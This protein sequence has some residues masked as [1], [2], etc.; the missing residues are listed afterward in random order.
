MQDDI[1]WQFGMG[2]WN[3]RG[4]YIRS[5]WVGDVVVDTKQSCDQQP[6]CLTQDTGKPGYFIQYILHLKILV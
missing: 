5:Q 2:R 1:L 3:F 6:G 4:N